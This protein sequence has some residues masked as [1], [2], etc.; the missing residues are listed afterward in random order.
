MCAHTHILTK[1]VLEQ[2]IFLLK[3]QQIKMTDK[4]KKIQTPLSH[5]ICYK[6]NRPMNPICDPRFQILQLSI[7]Y[8]SLPPLGW[9]LWTVR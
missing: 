3:S 8:D 1:I 5:N 2:Y 6:L 7:H 9:Q 4:K